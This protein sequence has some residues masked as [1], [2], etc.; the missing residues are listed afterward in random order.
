MLTSV[1]LLLV[2]TPGKGSPIH[3]HANAHCVMK[4]L[5]GRLRETIYGWPCQRAENPT[6][7]RSNTSSLYPST[8]H[9]CSGDKELGPTSLQVIRSTVYQPEQVTY[10]SDRLGLQRVE[11]ASDSEVA[12]SLH[13]YTVRCTPPYQVSYLF[14]LPY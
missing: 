7:C 2:W 14:V 13:L 8:E 10:M 4:I 12:I 6:P 9:S 5:K 1:Q 11:N 3:D